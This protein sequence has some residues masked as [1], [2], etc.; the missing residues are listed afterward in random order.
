MLAVLLCAAALAAPLN[1]TPAADPA[2]IAWQPNSPPQV[3]FLASNA[4]EAMYGGAAGGGKS[5]ALIAGGCRN[6]HIPEYK[7]ILFRRT[8]SDLK[9]TLIPRSRIVIPS[10]FPGAKYNSTDKFWKFESGAHLFFGSLEHEQSVLDY[11]SAEFQYVGFDEASLFT[12]FQLRYMKSRGRSSSGIPVRFRYGTNPGGPGHAHLLRSF[13]PWLLQPG[14]KSDDVPDFAGPYAKPGQKLW[15]DPQRELW[16]TAP[17]PDCLSRTF[18]PAKLSDN[19]ALR[20]DPTYRAG[21]LSQDIVTRAQLLDGNWL[22]KAA[23]GVLFKR[24][25]FEIVDAAPADAMMTI[26]YWDRAATKPHDTNK[27]PDWTRGVKMSRTKNGV[28]YIEH[29]ASDRDRPHRIEQLVKNTAELDGHRCIV[30]IEQDP[31]QAGVAEADSYVRLL[32]GWNVRRYKPTGDKVTR[33]Q[34]LS[35]QAEA[36]NVKLVRGAWN[37]AFLAELEQFPTPGVHDDQVDGSS[38]AFNAISPSTGLARLQMLATL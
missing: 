30:G 13:A 23:A 22:A 19:P 11:R 3:A 33:A 16:L 10:C 7:G 21:L 5:D 32:A 20:N 1:M 27:D 15:W 37:E 17:A 8:Y 25:Y 31:G 4:Y 12:E 24:S 2:A 6:A 29:V 34:P 28:F 38:G 26:R 36:G 18:I 14:Q 35:A 9:K